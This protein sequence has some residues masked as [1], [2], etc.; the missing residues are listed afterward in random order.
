MIYLVNFY[1]AFYIV[2]QIHPL[3]IIV[4]QQLIRYFLIQKYIDLCLLEISIYVHY[5]IDY[6]SAGGM[7]RDSR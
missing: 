7:D 4:R 6:H 1:F 2:F 5:Y 3:L